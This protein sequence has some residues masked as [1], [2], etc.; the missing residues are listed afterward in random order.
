MGLLL[1]R[2]RDGCYIEFRFTYV[3]RFFNN[4][5]VGV[6]LMCLKNFFVYDR[7][8]ENFFFMKESK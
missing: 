3:E 2:W 5:K 4:F 1:I 7:L 8:K 6:I